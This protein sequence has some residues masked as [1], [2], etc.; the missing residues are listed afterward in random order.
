MDCTGE[1]QRSETLPVGLVSL[2]SVL[3]SLFDFPE[4]FSPANVRYPAD[5]NSRSHF[6]W[7]VFHF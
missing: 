7:R 6:G 5:K 4:A 3:R 2:F 1:N